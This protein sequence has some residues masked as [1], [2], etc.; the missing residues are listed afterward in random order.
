MLRRLA[1]TLPFIAANF[2]PETR[3]PLRGTAV[4]SGLRLVGLREP[5]LVGRKKERAT[6][7]KELLGS[8]FAGHTRT[9]LWRGAPGNGITRLLRWAARSAHEQGLAEVVWASPMGWGVTVRR[10]LCPST[11]SAAPIRQ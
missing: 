9:Q 10:P 5:A 3:H 7:W 1:G 6:L 2:P 8:M 11:T 4:K